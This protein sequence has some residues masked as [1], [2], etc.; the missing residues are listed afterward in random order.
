MND[1]KIYTVNLTLKEM[2]CLANGISAFFNRTNAEGIEIDKFQVMALNNAM[3]KFKEAV[4]NKA[5]N[6]VLI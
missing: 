5:S 3:H 6:I 2:Q 1:D 4:E